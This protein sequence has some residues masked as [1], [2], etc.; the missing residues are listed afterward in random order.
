MSSTPYVIDCPLKSVGTFIEQ[1]ERGVTAV[2][3]QSANLPGSMI[4]V[5]V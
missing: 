3:K 4:V 2:T 1:S 5:N